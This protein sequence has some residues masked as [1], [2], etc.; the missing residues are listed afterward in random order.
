M[1]TVRSYS[2]AADT[3]SVELQGLGII[4][5]WIDGVKVAQTV[6]RGLLFYGA[7]GVL[8]M[9][10]LHRICEA[11]LVQVLPPSAGTGNLVQQAATAIKTETGYQ[12]IQTNGSG[13]G[14]AAITFSPAFATTPTVSAI[15]DLLYPVSISGV[16]TG[17]C[18]L[19]ISG[20]P[21]NAYVFVAWSATG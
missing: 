2:S 13:N 4:D 1:C 19:S 12:L 20:A 3:V 6:N 10:D 18:T 7:A 17:G 5:T 16:S 9:P 21:A 8:A 15:A 11:S 14:S